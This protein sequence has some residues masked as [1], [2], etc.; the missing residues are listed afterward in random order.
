MVTSHGLTDLACHAVSAEASCHLWWQCYCG[1]L[2]L[3]TQKQVE[4]SER[5]NPE[6][7]REN[8]FHSHQCRPGVLLVVK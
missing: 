2:T 7:I 6:H 8:K 1:S 3:Q 5:E 4:M